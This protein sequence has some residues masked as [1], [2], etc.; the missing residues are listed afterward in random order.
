MKILNLFDSCSSSFKNCQKRC[1]EQPNL[2]CSKR[3]STT[4]EDRIV[5][6]Q[7]DSV[8]LAKPKQSNI[9]N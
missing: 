7:S 3:I 6:S 2:F 4:V 5:S 8:T 9:L 1:A